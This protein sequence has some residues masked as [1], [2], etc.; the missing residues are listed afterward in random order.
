MPAPVTQIST[1][2]RYSSWSV[3]FFLSSPSC[4]SVCACLS[5]YSV[6][7]HD[8]LNVSHHFLQTTAPSSQ[9]ASFPCP[10]AYMPEVCQPNSWPM[11]GY[12]SRRCAL[13]KCTRTKRDGAYW[14]R[15]DASC[16]TG[17]DRTLP[18]V[19]ESRTPATARAPWVCAVSGPCV[20]VLLQA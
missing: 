2:V 14:S 20:R 19:L 7:A 13:V 1:T 8:I 17:S 6:L 12:R 4:L 5:P 3:S 10:C 9:V 16:L 11:A 18:A 15:V